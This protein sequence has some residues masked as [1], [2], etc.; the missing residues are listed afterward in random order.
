M[1]DDDTHGA[2]VSPV[3]RSV[4]EALS[5]G[6]ALD[7]ATGGGRNALF[8]A[9]R[10]WSV[11][12]VDLS[13]VHLEWARDR[14]GAHADAI[15]FVLA[16]VDSYAFPEAAYDLVTISF[17]DAR[18]RL[19]AIESTLAP[20]GVL[21]YEHYLESGP[22]ESGAGDRYRFAPNELLSATAS[23]RVLYYAE[24]RV[25]GEPR[26]TL[27]ASIPADGVDWAWQPP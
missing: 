4:L 10:G 12:A 9:A 24:Y 27:V 20:G 17:F 21:F 14:A 25:D 1:T 3:L 22:G 13:R 5:V 7:L 23:L 2:D 6:R 26:V 15:E 18:D 19:S 8:L 11:D 16:D